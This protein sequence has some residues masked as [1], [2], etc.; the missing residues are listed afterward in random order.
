VIPKRVVKFTFGEALQQKGTKYLQ[1]GQLSEVINCRRELDGPYTKRRGYTRTV[2]AFDGASWTGPARDLLPGDGV[3]LLARDAADDV[4]VLDPAAAR[5]RFR[6]SAKRALP[7]RSVINV[8]KVQ[9]PCPIA[10]QVGAYTW[11]FSNSYDPLSGGGT[12]EAGL[13]GYGFHLVVTETAT[14]IFV[15]R[16][17]I[18]SNGAGNVLPYY[19]SAAYDGTNVWL[20]TAQRVGGAGL[21]EAGTWKFTASDPSI[22]PAYAIYWNPPN[23]EQVTQIAMRYLSVVGKVAVVIT[24]LD[25]T[26]PQS[27]VHRSYINPATGVPSGAPAA[28]VVAAVIVG[29]V[30][31]TTGLSILVGDGTTSW[32]YAYWGVTGGGAATASLRLVQVTSA[33]LVAAVTTVL[34]TSADVVDTYGAGITSGYVDTV[35]GNRVVFAQYESGATTARPDTYVVNKYV[36]DGAATTMTVVADNA[37]LASQPV[38]YGGAWYFLTGYDDAAVAPVT[39][40]GQQRSLYLRDS[41]GFII[42]QIG[43]GEGPALYH[44]PVSPVSG[45][46]FGGQFIPFVPPMWASGTSLYC[47]V[48][49]AG[50]IDNA[51]QVELIAFD[52]AASYSRSVQMDQ[53]AVSPGGVVASWSES[54]DLT[55]MAPMLFPSYIRRTAGAGATF[56]GLAAVYRIITPDGTITRSSPVIVTGSFGA[57]DTVEVPLLTHR[58]H[59]NVTQNIDGAASAIRASNTTKVEI[60]IYAGTSELHLQGIVKYD[61]FTFSGAVSYVLPG[62]T[63]GETLYTTGGALSNAPL[64]PARAV[65]SWRNRLFMATDKGVSFT[66]EKQSGFGPAHS[67]A[68]R[69][70]WPDG[71]GPILA[72]C[73]VDWNYMALFKAD[74]IGVISG[75]GPD[76]RGIGNY[77]VQTLNTKMGCNNPSSVANGPNGAHFQDKANGRIGCVT[78]SLQVVE[79]ASGADDYSAEVITAAVHVED[80]RH[81][82]FHTANRMIVI[83]YRHPTPLAPF[84]QVY[85]WSGTGLLQAF[86]ACVD[87]GGA[88]HIEAD[89]TLRRPSA[90]SFRD[91]T[92]SGYSDYAQSLTTGDLQPAGQQEEFALSKVMFLGRFRAAHSGITWN[93]YKDFVTTAP[94]TISTAN[95]DPVQYVWRP[96]RCGRIQAFR[97]QIV[98]NLPSL[99]QAFDFEGV[100]VEIQPR[101][102]LAMLSPS[103]YVTPVV[104]TI[105]RQAAGGSYAINSGAATSS[106]SFTPTAAGDRLVMTVGQVGGYVAS[107]SG[108]AVWTPVANTDDGGAFAGARVSAYTC[109]APSTAPISFTVSI[110]GA[111]LGGRIRIDSYKSAGGGATYVS[112]T[113]TSYSTSGSLAPSASVITPDSRGSF[114]QAQ[115]TTSGIATGQVHVGPG[116]ATFLGT[117]QIG[118]AINATEYDFSAVDTPSYVLDA[119]GPNTAI[120]AYQLRAEIA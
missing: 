106:G 83:D 50:D 23:F 3:G 20:M 109:I 77:I 96:D 38:Q 6:G 95:L 117:T 24:A 39:I 61:D 17:L 101:G 45:G 85:T 35:T 13:F 55:E 103:S 34:A 104:S 16:R 74:A 4:W 70:I 79:A 62:T 110:G 66:Q 118:S 99:G 94:I 5:W 36:W 108:G 71:S 72:M 12:P 7:T 65:C 89:G 56:T 113:A 75:A 47:A 112:A 31:C 84:G 40:A 111:T 52:M 63:S 114:T 102:R 29:Q 19:F 58:L 87:A 25:G 88:V 49:M 28:V 92:A 76:G 60:E 43:Y 120:L 93:I 80:E 14:G 10:V 115:I 81:M 9:H 37:W 53:F 8:S 91:A 44:M 119:A 57:G 27:L 67:E 105:V 46:I 82:R 107:I 22:T 11:T 98:E 59:N 51:S 90:S 100:G 54:N 18:T 73:P 97:L 69:F 1:Q 78:P 33:T 64:P 42:T 41:N 48:A 116:F 26:V 32:Y 30:R 68:L 15:Y 21:T 86:A 2:N